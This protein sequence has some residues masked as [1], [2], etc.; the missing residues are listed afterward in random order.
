VALKKGRSGIKIMMKYFYS[1]VRD[2]GREFSN[3]FFKSFIK[4]KC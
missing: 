4:R 1:K 2:D 3:K